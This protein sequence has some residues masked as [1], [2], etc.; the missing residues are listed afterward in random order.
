[1]K[2]ENTINISAPISPYDTND[3]YPTHEAK[4][5]KGGLR[6]VDNVAERDN[7]PLELREDGMIVYVRDLNIAYI[8]HG[9]LANTNWV[10]FSTICSGIIFSTTPPP[11]PT[12]ETV[13]Y[14]TANGVLS[15]RDA[16]NS[17]W[18][19]LGASGI[20]GGTF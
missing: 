19:Q 5:G 7:I 17:N 6:A 4:Y 3:T 20:D 8:L 12:P 13:W 18:V 16:T 15:F 9:G 2:I 10:D 11:V 1:M 14:N